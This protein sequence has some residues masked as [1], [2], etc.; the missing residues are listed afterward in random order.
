MKKKSLTNDS[1]ACNFGE[2]LTIDGY[3]GDSEKLN[4]KN[5]ILKSLDELPEILGMKKLSEPQVHYAPDNNRKDPGGWSGFVIV[6]ESH[7]SI[8]TFPKRGFLSADV[9][10]CKN[11]LNIDFIANYFKEKFD[12]KN[13]ETNFIK[14][15]TLYPLKNIC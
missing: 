2:H 8:H 5:L 3:D 14:R 10:S 13:L 6:A 1:S 7:I 11:G 12:L 4:D 9:Y 15:G